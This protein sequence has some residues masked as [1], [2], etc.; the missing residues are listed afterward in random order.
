MSE[1]LKDQVAVVVGASSGMGKQTALS[2][3]GAGASL[4]VAARS[5]DPLRELAAEIGARA[6]AFRADAE[7]PDSLERLAAASVE[8]FGRIDI[9]VYATGTNI[10]ERGLGVLTPETWDMMV[11]TNLSGAF[12]C[13]RAVLGRSCAHRG[14]D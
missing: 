10:P 13:T 14:R 5:E 8:R 3:A 11:A 12:H 7:D 6:L 9:L 2:L 4:V 1:A